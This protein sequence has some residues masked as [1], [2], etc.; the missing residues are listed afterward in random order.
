MEDLRITG[1]LPQSEHL[2]TSN[3]Y[4][5]KYHHMLEVNTTSILIRKIVKYQQAM[6]LSLNL[7]AKSD[8]TNKTPTEARLN[9]I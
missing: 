4:S 8:N 3:R 6:H 7:I 9:L 2:V 1:T 5:A